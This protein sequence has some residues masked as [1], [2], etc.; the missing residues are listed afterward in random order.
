MKKEIKGINWEQAAQM[1]HL[2]IESDKMWDPSQVINNS[3]II[4]VLTFWKVD[5]LSL[6]SVANSLSVKLMIGS[7]YHEL[8]IVLNAMYSVLQTHYT[9]TI[10]PVLQ[11]NKLWGL[12]CCC[13]RGKCKVAYNHH[14]SWFPHLWNDETIFQLL[15]QHLCC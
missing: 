4:I 2:L 7:L 14:R 5:P 1:K 9:D 6:F 10:C 11:V 12:P 3:N 13:C 15:F 8:G